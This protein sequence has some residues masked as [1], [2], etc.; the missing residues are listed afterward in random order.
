MCSKGVCPCAE[1]DV[2]KWAPYEK[3]LLLGSVPSKI[4][5]PKAY[6]PKKRRYFYFKK[7]GFVET[8][9]QCHDI[10]K[11]RFPA[12]KVDED[13]IKVMQVVE[14]QLNCQGICKQALFWFFRP[15]GE[16]Q[17]PRSCAVAFKATYDDTFGAL[18]WG[19][20]FSSIVGFSLAMC[21]CG[22]FRKK[23]SR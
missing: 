18:G 14:N 1:V 8:F 11:E 10:Y 21:S 20:L 4:I 17:P 2:K 15:I 5:K 3:A 16:G 19:L 9:G 22:L 7:D 6:I 23:K 12:A 13:L